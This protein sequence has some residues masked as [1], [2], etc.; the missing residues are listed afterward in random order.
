MVLNQV[1]ATLEIISFGGEFAGHILFLLFGTFPCAHAQREAL[2]TGVEQKL[3][4]GLKPLKV[5]NVG[6]SEENESFLPSLFS[7]S[8]ILVHF[9]EAMDH[10]INIIVSTLKT[11]Y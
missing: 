7:T 11:R 6:R 3:C 4:R 8:R 10:P 1:H 9:I 5:E 2:S